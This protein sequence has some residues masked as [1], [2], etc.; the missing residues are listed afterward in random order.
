MQLQNKIKLI[1]KLLFAMSGE[2]DTAYFEKLKE[3]VEAEFWD[4]F[5]LTK[6]SGIKSDQSQ[7]TWQN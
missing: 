3:K 6:I 5:R 1:I 4:Q 2:D 7:R